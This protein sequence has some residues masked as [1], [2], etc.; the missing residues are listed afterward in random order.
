M[1]AAEVCTGITTL[2]EAVNAPAAVRLLVDTGIVV[3]VGENAKT[4]ETQEKDQTER[5]LLYCTLGDAMQ[6]TRKEQT[7]RDRTGVFHR[8]TMG[9]AS[10]LFIPINKILAKMMQHLPSPVGDV[11][12]SRHKLTHTTFL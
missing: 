4:G 6:E 3:D 12:G 1:E 10:L 8:L 5:A 2:P 9:L 11:I 7:S